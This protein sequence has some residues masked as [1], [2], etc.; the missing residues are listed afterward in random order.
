MIT[1]VFRAYGKTPERRDIFTIRKRS[2]V[3]QFEIFLK[4]WVGRT[5]FLFVQ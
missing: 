2:V 3:M 1:A 5:H 4:K